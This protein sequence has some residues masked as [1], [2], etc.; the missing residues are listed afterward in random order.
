M[1]PP[2]CCGGH[3]FHGSSCFLRVDHGGGQG[4][5]AFA[6]PS[7]VRQLNPHVGRSQK[8]S[9]VH[10]ESGQGSLSL[11]EQMDTNDA[12]HSE[13]TAIIVS[14]MPKHHFEP[15][16]HCNTN[17]WSRKKWLQQ[18]QL[19]RMSGA[20]AQSKRLKA[21]SKLTSSAASVPT[22]SATST[23]LFLATR[24]FLGGH[25]ES[26]DF[27]GFHQISRVLILGTWGGWVPVAFCTWC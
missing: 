21:S 4:P 24:L 17:F 3:P 27:R 25:Q 13:F 9:Q 6:P 23:D 8:R 14:D 7:M 22:S 2:P 19:Q 12:N 5:N 16:I 1:F 20:S 18:Q 15:A 11:G 10:L 26:A